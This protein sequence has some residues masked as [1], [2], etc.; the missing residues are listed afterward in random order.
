M[1]GQAETEQGVDCGHDFLE[2]AFDSMLSQRTVRAIN[3]VPRAAFDSHEQPVVRDSAVDE[4]RDINAV[5]LL[6]PPSRCCAV[7]DQISAEALEPDG[8]LFADEI[9]R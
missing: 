4:K 2:G 5:G 7:L 9:Q 3:A 6:P 1:I 8:I